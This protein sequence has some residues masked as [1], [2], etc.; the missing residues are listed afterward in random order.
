[1][2]T[3][4]NLTTKKMQNRI[5]PILLY[6]LLLLLI[7]GCQRLDSIEYSPQTSPETFLQN[8]HWVKIQIGDFNFI[9]SQPT[10]TIIVYFVGLFSMYAGYTFLKNRNKQQSKLWWG[11]GLLLAGIGALFAGTSYQAFGYEIK[12][13]GREFCTWTS[14]WEI[15]YMLLSVPSMNAFLVATAYSNTKGNFRKV[16]MVYAVLNTIGYT[17][18]LLYGALFAVKF[19][20]SFECMSLISAPS[21][22]FLLV[23]HGTSYVKNK[24]KM[25]LLLLNSWLIFVAVG[26]SYGAYLS[27]GIAAL[28]WKKDIW[29]TENDV[30]HVGMICWVYYIYKKISNAIIDLE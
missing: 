7:S 2:L 13:N 3:L 9:W 23:L 16:I 6:P 25:N 27:S 11:I 1:M 15:I 26:I 22:I 28:L 14:W 19:A 24:D 20:V 5:K 4:H 8:Q 12:C 30:L 10:S 17:I 21:V 18:L 29:F